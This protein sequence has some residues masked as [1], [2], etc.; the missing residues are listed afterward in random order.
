MEVISSRG[1][2]A[3]TFL[4]VGLSACVGI[5]VMAPAAQASTHANSTLFLNGQGSTF[6]QPLMARWTFVYHSTVN[7]SIA[8]NYQGTGSGAGIK[9]FTAKLVDFAAS[10]GFMTDAQEKAAGGDVL[11]IPI[12]LGPVAVVYNLPGF[13]GDLKLDGPTLAQIYLGKITNWSDKAIA[14]LNPGMTLPS[15]TIVPAHRADSSGTTFIFTNYLSAVSADFKSTV[16]A[17]TAVNFPGGQGGKGTP[18]VAS[19][20]SQSPGGI[21]YVELSYALQRGLPVIAMKNKAGQF[22]APSTAG[23][24]ADA[25]N[26]PALPSDLR[27]VIVDSPGAASYPITGF[28]WALIHQKAPDQTKSYAVLH[29]LWWAITT[30]QSYTSSGQLRYAPLPV[31]LVKLDEA[32]IKSVTYNGKPLY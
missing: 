2:R 16:G 25:A 30:G 12:A 7:K 26:A 21:G 14:A 11:H 29:F 19:I 20:V 22:V 9:A 10:D 28:T 17:A 31:S 32:K 18:G 4:A 23:A 6:V 13:K 5:G 1:R 15:Q 3:R 8:V 27:A 24:S